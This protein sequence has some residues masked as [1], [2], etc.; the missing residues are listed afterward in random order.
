M[1]GEAKDRMV[2]KEDRDWPMRLKMHKGMPNLLHVRGRLPGEEEKTA[3]IVGARMCS[4][5]GRQ[6]AFLFGKALA[7]AGVSV[8]SGMARGVDSYA[9]A[10]A[11]EAAGRT[12]GVLGCGLD[13]CYPA[14]NRRLYEQ[15]PEKGGLISEFSMGVK[16]LGKHFPMRNRIISALSDIVLVVEAKERSGSLITADFALEQGKDVFAVPGRVEDALSAGCNRLIA[17]GAGIALCPEM[18]LEAMGIREEN[19]KSLGKNTKMGLA[20]DMDLVYSCVDLQPKELYRILE[21]VSLPAERTME[22][23]LQLQ[24]EGKVLEVFRNCYVKV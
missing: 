9:H 14:Q 23:L 7:E 6:Q 16:P 18:L 12:Y 19:K 2:K 1:T 5:Y 3:A 10:G 11:L 13:I 17:Q 24:M 15:I 4:P 8:I 21:E 22:I 20:T